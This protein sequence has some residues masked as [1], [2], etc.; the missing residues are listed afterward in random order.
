MIPDVIK[1]ALIHNL[2]KDVFRIANLDTG[3]IICESKEQWKVA[4][5]FYGFDD[6]VRKHRRKR[7]RRKATAKQRNQKRK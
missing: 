3:Q 4:R 1:T 5:V 6:L 7:C 2:K